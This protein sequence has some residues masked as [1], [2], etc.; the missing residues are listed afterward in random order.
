MTDDLQIQEVTGLPKYITHTQTIAY[1]ALYSPNELLGQ[2][3]QI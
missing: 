2:Q 1:V 3:N